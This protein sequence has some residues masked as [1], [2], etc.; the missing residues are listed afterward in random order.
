MIQTHLAL[1][2]AREYR[3][4]LKYEPDEVEFFRHRVETIYDVNYRLALTIQRNT[5]SIPFRLDAFQRKENSF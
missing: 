2:Y 5:D 4:T 3:V 1:R